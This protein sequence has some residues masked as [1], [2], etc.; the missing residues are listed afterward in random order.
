MWWGGLN[1]W[2]DAGDIKNISAGGVGEIEW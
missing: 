1:D 2:Q